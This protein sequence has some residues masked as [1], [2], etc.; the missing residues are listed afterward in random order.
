MLT[1]FAE[2]LKKMA[3]GVRGH[4]NILATAKPYCRGNKV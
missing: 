4:V 3:V 2:K 1:N